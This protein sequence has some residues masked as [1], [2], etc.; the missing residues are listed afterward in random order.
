MGLLYI[1]YM[2]V[3]CYVLSYVLRWEVLSTGRSCHLS[4]IRLTS[5]YWR[6]SNL[7]SAGKPI[8]SNTWH[9]S[10][11]NRRGMDSARVRFLQWTLS[12]KWNKEVMKSSAGLNQKPSDMRY[13]AFRI[14]HLRCRYVGVGRGWTAV[15]GR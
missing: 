8:C 7:G 14:A 3:N 6:H 9:S 11:G 15:Y 2:M 1:L 4:T 5:Q 13:R 12:S 10:L